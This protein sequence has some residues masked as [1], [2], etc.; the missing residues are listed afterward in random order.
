V[1]PIAF[2]PLGYP[3]D[4]SPAKKRKNL[5]DLVKYSHW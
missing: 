1:D 4:E 2:T 5:A 3:A